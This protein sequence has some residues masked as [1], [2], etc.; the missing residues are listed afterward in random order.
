MAKLS[1]QEYILKAAKLYGLGN[2]EIE[3]LRNHLDGSDP[4]N[5][6]ERKENFLFRLYDIYNS[7]D[8]EK[9]K[10]NKDG[11]INL[12]DF[13]FEKSERRLAD[14][15]IGE[16]WV[17][18]STLDCFLATT[19]ADRNSTVK[20]KFR[21]I[22][23]KNNFL[24]PQLAKEMGLSTTVYHKATYRTKYSNKYEYHLSKNFLN[25]DEKFIQGKAILKDVKNGRRIKL[26]NLLDATDRYIKKHCKKYDIGLETSCDMRKEIRRELIKQ[27]F[28]NKFVLNENE[29]NLKWGL[30]ENSDHKLRVAPL[31]SFDYCCGAEPIG[32][33][34]RRTV[35]RKEDIQSFMLKYGDEKWFSNWIES[36]V[37]NNNISVEK[38]EK[39]MYDETRITL[40]PEEKQYYEYML[41]EQI[42]PRVREVVDV[43]YDKKE[44][45]SARSLKNKFSSITAS[46]KERKELNKK[47]EELNEHDER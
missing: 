11:V 39:K 19:P 44:M 35:N 27:S 36:K 45:S 23:E 32:K 34:H 14:S 2:V 24:L 3:A 30:L 38:L 46:F 31:Y 28:F 41:K 33:N 18:G 47:V 42:M 17:I 25:E 29:S 26:E 5:F 10:M 1:K 8:G 21:N 9:I 16:F 22:S 4:N 12:N 43:S 13:S 6:I 7:E 37:I 15:K 40:T 20:E